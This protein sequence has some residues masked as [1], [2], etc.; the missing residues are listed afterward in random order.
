MSI[1]KSI[2]VLQFFIF[3]SASYGQL[4]A[5]KEYGNH[6]GEFAFD[7]KSELIAFYDQSTERK[8]NIFQV[9]DLN[10]N[11]KINYIKFEHLYLLILKENY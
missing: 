4:L 8:E 6:P 1:W 2:V 5:C 9:W 11:K 3:S 7:K 10:K